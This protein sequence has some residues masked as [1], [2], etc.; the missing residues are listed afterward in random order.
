M[1]HRAKYTDSY[2]AAR[3]S[4][5]ELSRARSGKDIRSGK[6]DLVRERGTL[7]NLKCTTSSVTIVFTSYG[8]T[9]LGWYLESTIHPT[10]G[11]KAVSDSQ[12]TGHVRSRRP[13]SNIPTCAVCGC[14]G[15]RC[16]HL[17]DS[18]VHQLICNDLDKASRKQLVSF[19]INYRGIIFLLLR[20]AGPSD[21]YCE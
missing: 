4:K 15:R 3:A 8:R 7:L 18:R 19:T 1:Q 16:H 10:H 13:N 6:L 12:P 20:Q 5:K 2:G 17:L 9:S 21:D 14:V 11:D